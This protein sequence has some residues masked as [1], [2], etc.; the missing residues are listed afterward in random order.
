MY[1][2]TVAKQNKNW[3]QASQS[4]VKYVDKAAVS[5]RQGC[6]PCLLVDYTYAF[7]SEQTFVQNTFQS[8]PGAVPP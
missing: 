3:K 8:V 5:A 7:L 2:S 4:F 6:S 1:L